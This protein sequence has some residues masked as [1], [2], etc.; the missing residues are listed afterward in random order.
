MLSLIL[1]ALI[2]FASADDQQ[3]IKQPFTLNTESAKALATKAQALADKNKWDVSIAI[4]DAGGNLIYFQRDQDAYVGSVEASIAKAKSANNFKRATAV[5]VD[6]VQKQG[7][8]GLLSIPGVVAAEGG[9]PIV[10]GGKHFGGI[11]VSGVR[12]V[13][14]EQVA[15][16]ALEAL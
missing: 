6:S 2:S 9:L 16:A 4:V 15:K 7:R 1:A 12:S 14:D 10:V 5:F 13:E 11:G 3:A 8:V